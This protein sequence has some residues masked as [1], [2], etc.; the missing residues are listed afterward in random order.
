MSP[1]AVL[2]HSQTEKHP[3]KTKLWFHGRQL[4]TYHH[5]R[6]DVDN[7]YARLSRF[8]AGQSVGLVLG[9]GGARGLAHLGVIRALEDSGIPIDFIGGTSQG[10][11]M[12]ALYANTLSS[13]AMVEPCKQFGS[14]FGF[15]RII[16]GL[17]LPVL[18][19]FHGGTFT[20][21]IQRALGTNQIED[22]WIPYFCITTNMSSNDMDIHT[23]GSL[24]KYVRASMSVLGLLPPVI[25]SDGEIMVDGGYVNNLPVD[26]M[27]T[28]CNPALI[29]ASDV[30]DKDNSSFK[31]VYNYGM[32]CLE[33]VSPCYSLTALFFSSSFFFFFF[34]CTSLWW[35]PLKL[36]S[37]T[38]PLGPFSHLSSLPL[39]LFF[40]RLEYLR[41]VDDC[42]EA[43]FFQEV[44]HFQ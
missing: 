25:D 18:S 22:L 28:V 24:W 43:L 34:F 5:V 7:D 21:S 17:T 36:W 32:W 26:I 8:I 20:K 35:S 33:C 41:L 31:D 11:F 16:T 27:Q 13:S 23:V 12:G 14:I 10:A 1:Y 44:C 42:P 9:G 37:H 29:I 3:T 6:Y 4:Q 38:R 30:E 19:W 15:F 2:L 40:R 39:A